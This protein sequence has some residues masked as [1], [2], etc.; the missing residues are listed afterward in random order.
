MRQ[1][2]GSTRIRTV[3]VGGARRRTVAVHLVA[4]GVGRGQAVS[5]T[6]EAMGDTG[7]I[8]VE[9]PMYFRYRDSMT[10]GHAAAGHTP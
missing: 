8:L 4:E 7:A 6:V 1:P 3:T 5:A 10:G 2:T 9:R